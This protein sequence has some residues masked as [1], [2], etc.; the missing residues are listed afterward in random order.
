VKKQASS[1]WSLAVKELTWL[2]NPQWKSIGPIDIG[3]RVTLHAD[4]AFQ[5]HI[6]VDVKHA[7]KDQ[8]EGVVVGIFDRPTLAQVRGGE[9]LDLQRRAIHFE[10]EHV[11]AVTKR[12]AP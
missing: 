3:D 8:Y 12:L 5:Y 7:T 2:R 4:A 10:R 1:I 6:S 9:V 11:F